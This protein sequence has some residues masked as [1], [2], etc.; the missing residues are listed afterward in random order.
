MSIFCFAGINIFLTS[1]ADMDNLGHTCPPNSALWLYYPSLSVN[2]VKSIK[3]K[4][5]R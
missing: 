2:V 5:D 4:G 1:D 3:L